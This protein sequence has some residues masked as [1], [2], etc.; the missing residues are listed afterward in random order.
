MLRII[1]CLVE[2]FCGGIA[3]PDTVYVWPEGLN[4]PP[5]LKLHAIYPMALANGAD[6]C[7]Q[8]Y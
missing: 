1:K 3:V 5:A 2:I 4:K 8:G 6:L 7:T